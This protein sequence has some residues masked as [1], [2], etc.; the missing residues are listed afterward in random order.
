MAHI[1]FRVDEE[2]HRLLREYA[3]RMGTTIT[4]L[5][6]SHISTILSDNVLVVDADWQV[7]LSD[8]FGVRL[9]RVQY[10][11]KVSKSP[12]E[13]FAHISNFSDRIKVTAMHS[14]EDYILQVEAGEK[15]YTIS[16]SKAELKMSAIRRLTKQIEDKILE[17]MEL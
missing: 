15:T 4:D 16:A 2:T 3:R 17:E 8:F 14:L 6:T 1:G 11:L 5:F 9:T 13:F 7:T 12:I 10:F